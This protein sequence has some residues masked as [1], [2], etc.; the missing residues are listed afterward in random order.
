VWTADISSFVKAKNNLLEITFSPAVI[1]DSV[2]DS[3]VDYRLPDIRAYS[4]KAPYQYG[5]DWGPRFVT[6]GIWRP[7]KIEAW[8]M[9]R[10][11]RYQ[12]VRHE[13]TD[14][15]ASVEFVVA[16]DRSDAVGNVA[17][18]VEL[19]VFDDGRQVFGQA[20]EANPGQDEVRIPV[21]LENPKLWLCYGLGRPDLYRFEI[22]MSSGN[23]ILDRK[24]GNLGIREIELVRE[25]DS[26][27]ESFYFKLN[28]RPVFMKGANFIPMDNFI[29]RLTRSD[30]DELLGMA[31]DAHMNML[32]VWGGV[33]Y[34][35]ETFYDLCD[36]KGILVWQDFMFACNMY[37]GDSAF[38][39]NVRREVRDNI[40]RLR[41][42]P[43]LALW[44]GNN[45]VSEAWHNWGWQRSLNYS[46]EDSAEIWHNY[47][48]IFDT[49]IPEA[50][51]ELDPDRP[52]HPS[53]PTYGW[54]RD[55]SLRIG[56][57]H[58][59]GV[60]W[61]KKPF[62]AYGKK[63]G[64]FMSEY[65][66]QGMP[67]MATIRKFTLPSDRK[68]GSE[69]MHVHQKHPFG[70]QLIRQYME[71]EYIVPKDFEDYVYVSQLVQAY[72]IRTAIEAHR[73]DMPR[74][75]GTL[76]WQLNDCWPV[77]SWSS[78][79]YYK[80]RKALHYFAEKAYGNI[81]VSPVVDDENVCVYIVNDK[82]DTLSAVLKMKLV[83]FEGDRLWESDTVIVAG[84]IS[85]EAV[86]TLPTENLLKGHDRDNVVFIAGL[87]VRDKTVS[88]SLLYFEPPKGLRLPEANPD[89]RIEKTD[90][91]YGIEV[92]TDR[93]IKNLY[94]EFP[95]VEGSFSDNFVDVPPGDTVLFLFRT[96]EQIKD[97]EHRLLVYHLN[98]FAKSK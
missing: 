29:P 77:T 54:G 78:V 11:A 33:I 72:G 34:P 39:E 19:K 60:W 69:V 68:L 75:M 4:R 80:K 88:R 70:R 90:T 32:R 41:N 79:D 45:E 71:R 12:I 7:A 23:R 86:Y 47:L 2:K 21:V 13:V 82:A 89:I 96:N 27:G 35:G 25:K 73:R 26:V 15:T 81:L 59:W 93:L 40:V 84:G 28:G 3:Q 30:Y 87:Y 48:K 16:L 8:D 57:M 95:G 74:C 42:H 52:Y 37:P 10:I 6:C 9:A 97:I 58:Y 62:D 43:S 38:S 5:W 1:V 76:Y 91:G 22:V 83:D 53:S 98:K 18:R 51:A 17:T 65:G 50:I 66:F 67:P 61:G 31:A 85:S 94:L 64:R 14:T 55:E 49:I 46:A 63:I 36:R 92:S 24:T 56:D 44:C 20:A